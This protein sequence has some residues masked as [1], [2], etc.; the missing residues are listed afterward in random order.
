MSPLSRHVGLF[1]DMCCL[2]AGA[3]GTGH[4]DGFPWEAA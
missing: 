4:V 1:R 2:P 3:Q